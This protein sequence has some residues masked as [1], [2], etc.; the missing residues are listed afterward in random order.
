MPNFDA[1][2]YFLTV[3]APIRTDPVQR[4]DSFLSRRHI[5]KEVLARMPSGERTAASPGA[6]RPAPFAR[7]TRTHFARFAVIDDVPF[8]GRVGSDALVSAQFGPDPLDAQPVD[9]LGSPYLLF[10]ADFDASGDDGALRSY[11]AELWSDMQPELKAVFEH[12]AGFDAVTTADGFFAYLK[13]CQVETT[14]PFNDYW[15]DAPDLATFPLGA[16]K[17]G[18]GVALLVFL[19]SFFWGPPWL[20]YA[21][22]VSLILIVY[23][24]YRSALAFGA[25]PFPTSPAGSPQPDLRTVLKAL[26]LQ[27]EFTAFAIQA[28]SLRAGG[29]T[30]DD[31]HA[32]FGRFL[33]RVKPADLDGPT[34]RPGVIGA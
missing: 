31:L 19:A 3:L 18:A 33:A 28:Q 22:I 29:G 16:W 11:A 10:G 32:E 9:E 1:G 30:D 5:L 26:H 24:G 14:M 21:S 25:K 2:H 6:A 15:S 27:R 17:T 4:G 20:P 23:L 12:C 8:N 7:S 34:Q 13:T